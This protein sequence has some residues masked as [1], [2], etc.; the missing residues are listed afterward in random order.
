MIGIHS[1]GKELILGRAEAITLVGRTE[2]GILR[3]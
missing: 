3:E 1:L 2:S